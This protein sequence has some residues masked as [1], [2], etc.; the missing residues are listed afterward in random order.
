MTIKELENKIRELRELQAFADELAAAI[1]A[2]KDEIKAVMGSR[3]VLH[4]GEYTLTY[5][6]VTN[7]RIDTAAFKK[8]LPGIADVF[9]KESTTRRFCVS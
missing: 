3:E 4:V 9:T 1:D 7:A 8:A 5:K 6:T 2:A